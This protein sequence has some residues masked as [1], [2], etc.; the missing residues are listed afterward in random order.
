MSDDKYLI[1]GSNSFSGSSFI[2]NLLKSKSDVLVKGISRSN[3][4]HESLLAYKNINHDGRFEFNKLDLNNDL[5][6]IVNVI[7]I[8]KPNYIVNFAAQGMVAQSWSNPE[9]WYKTNVLAVVNLVDKI[10]KLDFIKKFVQISTPEV[11]GP[12]DDVKES[13]CYLPSSPYA[14]SKASADSLLYAYFTTHGFPVCYTRA[15]NVYGPYQQLY[16]IIPRAV[17]TILDGGKIP[18]HGGGKAVR[19]FIHIDDV[20]DATIKIAEHG[21]SGEVYH[22]SSSETINILELVKLIADLMGKD[23]NK[24]YTNT[25]DRVGQDTKYLMNA[26]K[27][28][29]EL[30]WEPVFKLKQGINDVIEWVENNFSYFKTIPLDY[31]HKE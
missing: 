16:R 9:H 30:G 19:S 31:I 5:I 23:V 26:S 20:S 4:Y 14:A 25:V 3:E 11:Y 15:S 29:K 22:L 18:L 8:F 1:L 27:S 2:A 17:Y 24:F 21:N 28:K 10:Y 6:E 7:K 12:C 13:M